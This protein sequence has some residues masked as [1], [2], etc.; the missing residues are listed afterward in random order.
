MGHNLYGE[1]PMFDVIALVWFSFYRQFDVQLESKNTS[2]WNI[3][4]I[5]SNFDE[6]KHLTSDKTKDKR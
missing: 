2:I 4:L 3:K 1:K 6:K 5:L